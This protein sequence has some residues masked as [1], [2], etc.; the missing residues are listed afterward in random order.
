MHYLL[1]RGHLI[2]SSAAPARS[3]IADRGLTAVCV[4]IGAASRREPREASK[5][6][7]Q[8]RHMFANARYCRPE[9]GRVRLA[10]L[11]MTGTGWAGVIDQ[12]D[13]PTSAQ[14]QLPIQAAE[15]EAGVVGSM[16]PALTSTRSI[17][18]HTIFIYMAPMFYGGASA[19][20]GAQPCV[21]LGST[22]D[23]FKSVSRRSLLSRSVRPVTEMLPIPERKW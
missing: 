21:F 19:Q 14:C 16:R 12:L 8:T 23:S 10:E 2:D 15:P 4:K 20:W 3:A 17:R 1:M 22:S 18:S 5:T 6:P 13:N 11:A 7:P 9:P